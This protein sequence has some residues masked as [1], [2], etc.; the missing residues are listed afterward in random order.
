MGKLS[1]QQ[2]GFAVAAGAAVLIG[3]GYWY[4]SSNRAPSF[5]TLTVTKGNVIQSVNES[6]EVLAENSAS[7]SFEESGQITSVPV[8][9]GASVGQGAVLA[10]LDSSSLADAL[11][12]AQAAVAVAQAN[13]DQLLSGTRP[14]QLA[15]DQS[16]VTAAQ[17]AVGSATASL[18]AAEGS[19]YNA[20]SDAISNQTDNLFENPQSTSPLFTVAS[21]DPQL[22]ANVENER[23][24]LGVTMNAWYAA[25]SSPNYDTSSL[26]ALAVTDLKAVTDYLYSVALAISDSNSVSTADKAAVATARTEVAA[27]TTGLTTA[28]NA[29]IAAKSALDI[30]QNQLLLAQAG[31]TS[32]Q[33]EAQKAAV[34]QAEAQEKSAQVALQHATLIAPFAGTVTNL[35]AQV[36]QVV[37]PGVPV[38]SLTNKAGLKVV[39]YASQTDAAEIQ[40]GDAANI[41]LDAY[42]TGVVFPG[43]VTMV[44]SS[45]TEI[46]SVPAYAVTLHFKGTDSRIKSGMTAH[47]TIITAE[48]DNVLEVPSNLVI[49]NNGNYFVVVKSGDGSRNQQVGIGIIGDTTTEIT[50]GLSAG[51]SIINL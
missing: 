15:I 12:Q 25:Q 37:S 44:D 35:T 14:E 3:G 26:A 2:I 50:S 31:A 17:A 34:A 47:A 33:I 41:T 21:N 7:L 48:H 18:G 9:E 43:T 40:D 45:Q 32:Q 29:L 27:A 39:V 51:D 6:G 11:S 8:S 28:E 42:G 36:G 22:T 24:A 5:G 4:I 19:A 46:N 49:N 20:A 16:T 1:K 10:E 38:L 23:Y 13:L 30:D